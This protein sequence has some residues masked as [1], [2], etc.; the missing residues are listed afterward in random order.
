MT[1]PTLIA[2]GSLVAL[3]LCCVTSATILQI[4][5]EASTDSDRLRRAFSIVDSKIGLFAVNLDFVLRA[6]F[7]SNGELTQIEVIPKH[8]FNDSHSE[9][10]EP[11]VPPHL[12]EADYATILKNISKVKPLGLLVRRGKVGSTTNNRTR[13][14]DAYEQAVVERGMLGN[15]ISFLTV[16]FFR[17]ISGT[18]QRVRDWGVPPGDQI[19]WV[20]IDDRWYW[21][22]DRSIK[23]F[24]I[25]APAVVKVA[26]PTS[27][28]PQ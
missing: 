4:P 28:A 13:F 17:K 23:R 26:G 2:R 15:K 7:D 6:H 9:W 11:D 19:L 18:L 20:E 24:K 21:T 8:F 1:F 3:S 27:D 16:F 14:L 12:S 22:T 5:R 25:G 10:A